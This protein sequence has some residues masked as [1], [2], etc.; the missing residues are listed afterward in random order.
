MFNSLRAI[1]A[2]AKLRLLRG[3]HRVRAI[4][5]HTGFQYGAQNIIV[6]ISG[7]VRPR[8]ARAWQT[9]VA[10]RPVVVSVKSRKYLSQGGQRHVVRICVLE[11]SSH[12]VG[13]VKLCKA[14]PVLSQTA[15]ARDPPD[16]L[17]RHELPVQ[18]LAKAPLLRWRQDLVPLS[19]VWPHQGV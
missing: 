2:S 16:S 12:L 18:A 14:Q 7:N 10:D 15:Q 8:G 13:L 5:S 17:G 6:M 1:S 4:L 9:G 11:P 3:S 19:I